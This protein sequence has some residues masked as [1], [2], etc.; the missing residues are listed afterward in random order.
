MKNMSKLEEQN[1]YY[2]WY[3]GYTC[4]K[5]PFTNSYSGY[6]HYEVY[7]AAT[8]GSVFTPYFGEKFDADKVEKIIRYRVNIV[9]PE[10]IK[11]NSN[12]S[13][14][15]KIDKISMKD[16]SAGNDIFSIYDSGISAYQSDKMQ[17][18]E[19][20]NN[21]VKNYTPPVTVDFWGKELEN[22]WITLERTVAM[23]DVRKQNLKLMPGFQ[24]SWYYTGI[25]VEPPAEYRNDRN[26]IVLTRNEIIQNIAYYDLDQVFFF[27]Y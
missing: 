27:K 20:T 5:L 14:F 8:S 18:N 19:E 24:I 26:K 10:S 7:T 3:H 1:R 15:F 13:L 9:P 22:P 17:I 16:L 6:N 21:I 4:I 25:E 23:H 11:L 12:V 2:N